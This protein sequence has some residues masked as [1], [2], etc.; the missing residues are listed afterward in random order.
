MTGGKMTGAELRKKYIEFF[1]Q[2]GHKE[3]PSGGLVPEHDPTALFINSGM[4][5]LVPYLLGQP[6]PLGKRLTS[7]QK[8]VRTDD[9]NEVGDATHLTFF[10]MLGNWSLGDYFKKDAITW[11]FEFLTSPK[12][13]GLNPAKIYVSVFAGDKDAPLDEESI[14]I[15]QEVFKTAGI[16]AKVGERIFTYPKEKNWWGPAGQTGPCGPDT[17]MF[18][19]TGKEHHKEFGK[20]CHPNCQCGKFVEIWNDVFMQFEKKADG[21]FTELKQ[22]NVDTGLGLEREV[23]ILQGRT[24]VYQTELFSNIIAKIEEISGKLE[25][26][27]Q[28]QRA[29]RIIAD[30][31]RA[32][33]FIIADGVLP[34]NKEQGSILR[35]LVRRSIRFARQ[36][37]M[38]ELFTNEIAQIV[39]NDYQKAY[40]E[41]EQNQKNI[42]ET[43]KKEEEK[44]AKT[45]D[46][47][48]KEWQ[49]MI[50]NNPKEISGEQAFY[51]YE[52][53]GFPIEI[54]QEL[55]GEK[56][57]LVDVNSFQ[58]EFTK[59]QQ[60]SREGAKQKFSGGLVD[61]SEETTKL[62]T[63]THLLQAA[64]RQVLGE[65]VQQAG[66]N[67]TAE[68]LRFDFNYSGK[69]EPEQLKKVESL[70]NEKIKDNLKVEMKIT[71]YQEA[72]KEGALGFFG[73]KYPEK[74]KVYTIGKSDKEFFSKEICG[75]PHVDFTGSLGSFKIIK[76]EKI[77]ASVQRIY[78]VAA[79]KQD[80]A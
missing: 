34:S 30:H 48:L 41:L 35:R 32:A 57:I 22:K 50:V 28:Y 68:R 60:K 42:L 11:S 58:E 45:L 14:K 55:A 38:E 62:H 16:K 80:S 73:H 56:Q 54:I 61:H 49:K 6:H 17:E 69:I 9:I 33:V 5:P 29:V 66:S 59:H 8:C 44:F 78:A 1:V 75:G 51:L 15:W 13:L 23:M 74:V 52:S 18:Y 47:G 70:V 4:H 19:D 3:I 36:L 77:A 39:I 43:L 64:L 2:K 20:P 37:G 63:A 31:L 26:Q 40:P 25:A 76:A 79:D 24:S 46:N 72:I 53:F 21:T 67:I 65:E 10:E 27:S 71:L 12:W 7:V